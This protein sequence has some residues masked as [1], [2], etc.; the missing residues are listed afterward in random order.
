MERSSSSELGYPPS[1]GEAMSSSQETLRLEK[2]HRRQCRQCRG[3]Y[4][5]LCALGYKENLPQ[6]ES[7][8]AARVAKPTELFEQ[9]DYGELI[10]SESAG[11]SS[12]KGASDNGSPQ[13]VRPESLPS[14]EKPL[15]VCQPL[16][17]RLPGIRAATACSEVAVLTPDQDNGYSSLEEEHSNSRMHLVEPVSPEQGCSGPAEGAEELVFPAEGGTTAEGSSKLPEVEAAADGREGEESDSDLSDTEEEEDGAEPEE[18]SP[19]HLPLPGCQNKAIAY[20]MG[21][22]CSEDSESDLEEDSDWDSEDDDGFDS[23][24]SSDFSDSEDLDEEEDREEEEEGKESDMGEADGE[25]EQLWNSLC[26]RGD[27]YDPRNFTASQQT[28]PRRAPG[29]DDPPM[30]GPSSPQPL[31]PEE[32]SW[33]E[34]EDSDLDEEESLRLWNSFTSGGDPYSPHGS[35]W[36]RQ[37]SRGSRKRLPPPPDQ[38]AVCS[39]KLKRVRF[40]EE[41]E[42]FYANSDEDRRGP[43]EE[44]ARDRCRFVRRVQETELAIGYCLT[45]TFRLVIFNR[46]HQSC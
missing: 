25:V 36:T 3:Q 16:C 7:G 37:D 10:P 17:E 20:I 22:P 15:L 29:G 28:A 39:A 6:V 42:E 38:T 24:G 12:H 19:P 27:P 33:E 4:G 21:G 46:L 35:F 23:E 13:S 11:H 43:W 40:A 31:L 5:R 18:L 14:S 32:E 1:G 26:P 44:F 34:E 41:V 8:T 2:V 30:E 9:R 45:P